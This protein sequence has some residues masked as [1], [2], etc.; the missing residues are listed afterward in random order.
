MGFLVIG[1][2]RQR[3]TQKAKGNEIGVKKFFADV[4]MH[5]TKKVGASQMK[6]ITFFSNLSS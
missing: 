1:I 3:L 6:N 5:I 2:V 4:L